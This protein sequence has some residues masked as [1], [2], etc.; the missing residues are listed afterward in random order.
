ME[1]YSRVFR[2]QNKTKTK[3]EKRL[4]FITQF[5]NDFLLT[6]SGCRKVL[7]K[8]PDIQINKS[9]VYKHLKGTFAYTRN[10]KDT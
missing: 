3:K 7:G 6:F 2:K 1:N 5:K 9:P 8:M 10:K 4:N